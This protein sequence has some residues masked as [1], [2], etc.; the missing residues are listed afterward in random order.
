MR[1]LLSLFMTLCVC[2][3]V[4][5]YDAKIDG[6]YYDLYNNSDGA[7]ATVTYRDQNYNSY[8]GEVVIPATI[9]YN[10]TEY[11][12]TSIGEH[13]FDACSALTNVVIPSSVNNIGYYAFRGCSSLSTVV[14][15]E[16][17]TEVYSRTFEDCSSLRSVTIP[18]G[19]TRIGSYAF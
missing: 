15:P 11:A 7:R 6:I 3:S 12:V 10:G 9:E 8:S 5:A 19:V 13:A 14:I 17:V 4:F 18:N 1:K 16:R 2:V